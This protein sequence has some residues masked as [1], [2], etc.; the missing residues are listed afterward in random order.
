M[1][2][3]IHAMNKHLMI[4]G[5]NQITESQVVMDVVS[6]FQKLGF[7]VIVSCTDDP[8]TF[9][10]ITKCATHEIFGIDIVAKKGSEI[11]VI[12]CKGETKGGLPACTA[13]MLS[14]IGQVL[15]RITRVSEEIHYALA[16]PNTDCFSTCA[17]KFLKSPALPLLNMSIILTRDGILEEI[18]GNI[19]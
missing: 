11:W 5:Q 14:G 13:T 18:T 10:D 12:E 17:R 4:Q 3:S 1:I 9:D 15:T 7:T 16:V 19:T 8:V 2:S 6:W